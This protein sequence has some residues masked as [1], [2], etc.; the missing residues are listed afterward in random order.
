MKYFIHS[1]LW[2]VRVKL[3]AFI[4]TAGI[5]FFIGATNF[6]YHQNEFISIWSII[7]VFLISLLASLIEHLCYRSINNSKA[8]IIWLLLAN[9][10]FISSSIIMNWFMILPMYVYGLLILCLQIG[11]IVLTSMLNLLQ[12]ADTKQLNEHLHSFKSKKTF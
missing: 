1:C 3:R 8:L 11:L 12:Q 2:L 10:T 6:I 7:Q 9:I 4:Y 5:L